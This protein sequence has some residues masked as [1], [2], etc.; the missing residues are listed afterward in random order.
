VN[1]ADQLAADILAVAQPLHGENNTDPSINYTV[2]DGL[3]A[4]PVCLPE[5]TL[6]LICS[7]MTA[8]GENDICKRVISSLLRD[9]IVQHLEMLD[10]CDPEDPDTPTLITEEDLND[11]ELAVKLAPLVS[12]TSDVTTDSRQISTLDTCIGY[13]DGALENEWGYSLSHCEREPYREAIAV[14]AVLYM[15]LLNRTPDSGKPGED[16]DD[17]L[18]LTEHVN[19]IVRYA[20]VVRE[21]GAF[22]IEFLM[23]LD[24]LGIVALADGAL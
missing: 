20:N 24:V 21:R 16:V 18:G 22:D 1:R 23:E 4:L 8:P 17:L 5:M 19:L 14:G 6:S 3:L 2:D 11:L 7:M 13:A 10:E 12:A 9:I 15:T